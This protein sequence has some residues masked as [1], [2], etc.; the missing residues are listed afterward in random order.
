MRV[1]IFSL[2]FTIAAAFGQT[3]SQIDQE[4]GK[5]TAAYSVSQHISM[6]PDFTADGQVCRM[7]LYP[8]H[9][10]PG[11]NYLSPS[12]YFEELNSALNRLVPLD[13]RG[14]KKDSFGL[15]DFG[16][17]TALTTYQY[18]KVTFVFTSAFRIGP[19]FK[20]TE[21]EPITFPVDE[22]LARQPKKTPPSIDDFGPSQSADTQVVTIVW[23]ERKCI[24]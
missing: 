16:G 14:E 19:D 1:V 7:R 11:I 17:G 6:T 3:R 10:G 18:E 4:Y 23:N 8:K 20:R 24:Q 2:T 9:I 22:V 5:P 13:R 12:L 21:V 15:T